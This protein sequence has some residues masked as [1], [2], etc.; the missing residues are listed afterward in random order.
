MQTFIAQFAKDRDTDL[1][2]A[3]QAFYNLKQ[4]L[5]SSELMTRLYF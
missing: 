1:E 3:W 5:Y 4:G 2:T